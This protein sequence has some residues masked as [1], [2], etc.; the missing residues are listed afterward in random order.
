MNSTPLHIR[1]ISADGY[2]SGPL[3]LNRGGRSLKA[4]DY[5]VKHAVYSGAD[6]CDDCRHFYE[7]HRDHFDNIP[8]PWNIE[9]EAK[10]FGELNG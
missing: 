1:Q 2:D 4:F 8:V 10:A 9:D 6:V 3:C 5:Q 7:T